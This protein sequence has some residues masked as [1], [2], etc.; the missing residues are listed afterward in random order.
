MKGI[1]TALQRLLSC[2]ATY[3]CPVFSFELTPQITSEVLRQQC[4][5]SFLS[6]DHPSRLIEESHSDGFLSRLA[7]MAQKKVPPAL[8]KRSREPDVPTGRITRARTRVDP[9]AAAQV[10]N[11]NGNQGCLWQLGASRHSTCMA[12]QPSLWHVDPSS[13]CVSAALFCSLVAL[14]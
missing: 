6:V 3:E 11:D 5:R 9:A 7:P 12:A 1:T 14:A 4:L 10:Q 13:M 2:A 8:G